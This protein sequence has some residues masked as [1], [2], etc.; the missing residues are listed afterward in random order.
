MVYLITK[1]V[2]IVPETAKQFGGW[3]SDYSPIRKP[4]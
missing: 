3:C 2:D 1:I 4:D